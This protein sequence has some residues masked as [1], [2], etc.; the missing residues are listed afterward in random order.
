MY[1]LDHIKYKFDEGRGK[2]PPEIRGKCCFILTEGIDKIRKDFG[3]PKA[4]LKVFFTEETT[5]W[6]DPD[7]GGYGLDRNRE[8]GRVSTLREATI[9]QNLAWMNGHAPRIYGLVKV[10]RNGKIYPAQVTEFIDGEIGMRGVVKKLEEIETPLVK[11]GVRTC[12]NNLVSQRDFID[13]KLID[14]QGFT[15][16][17]GAKEKIVAYIRETGK[18]GK[19]HYQSIPELG[20]S[21]KPRDTEKRIKT[22]GLDKVDFK[23]KNVLDIGCNSGVFCN[24]ASKRGAKRVL[25]VDMPNNVKAAQVLAFYLGYH[26]NDYLPFDL[27]VGQPPVDFDIDITL[28]LS[29]VC[30]IGL[31]DWIG[32][33]TKELLVMEE[34]AR[35]SKYVTDK[36]CKELLKWFNDVYIFGYTNDHNKNFPKPVIWAKK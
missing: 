17:N 18:Y 2:V 30:H 29:M 31:P 12:H 35:G 34:N 24:Y 26:N 27:S 10:E 7:W 4:V 9:I 6:G 11:F 36:W 5:T 3:R 20:V 32:E 19:A 22:M 33:I 15:F 14:F 28:F 21:A 13:G 25:G 8:I 16:R 23:G 1:N